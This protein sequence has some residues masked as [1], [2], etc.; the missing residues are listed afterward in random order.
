MGLHHGPEPGRQDPHLWSRRWRGGGRDGGQD[1]GLPLVGSSLGRSPGLWAE[2]RP[3]A[4]GRVGT[5]FRS[6]VPLLRPVS[7]GLLPSFRGSPRS[8]ASHWASPSLFRPR[9]PRH[10]RV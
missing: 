2:G 10:P 8:P 4:L 5:S 3:R 6:E 9:T 7:P 1:G